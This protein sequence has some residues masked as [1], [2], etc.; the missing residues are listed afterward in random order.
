MISQFI[1]QNSSDIIQVKE[2]SE[3]NLTSIRAG[4]RQ[5]R[6]DHSLP[7]RL[8]VLIDARE[9]CINV[10]PGNVGEII[11]ETVD[12]CTRFQQLKE[13]IVLSNPRDT[14]MAMLISTANRCYNYQLGVFSTLEAALDWLRS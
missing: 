10:H 12:G 2:R 9:T 7:R 1:Y 11:D 14:A 3:I 8:K 4:F 13:A 5:I 6:S